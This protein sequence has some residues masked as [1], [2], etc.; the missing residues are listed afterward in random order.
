MLA[1][2]LDLPIGIDVY[3][4]LLSSVLAVFFTFAALASDLLWDRYKRGKRAKHRLL[5]RGRRRTV[6]ASRLSV[7]AREE[8]SNPLLDPLAEEDE[9][10]TDTQDPSSN[11]DSIHALQL[12]AEE[13]LPLHLDSRPHSPNSTQCAPNGN[14]APEFTTFSSNLLSR[15]PPTKPL[16]QDLGSRSEIV[17]PDHASDK[18]DFTDPV[19]RSSSERSTSHRSSSLVDSSGSSYGLSN[20]KDIAYRG[21]PPTK[22][23]FIATVEELYSGYTRKNI[24]KGFS[25]SLAITSMH[26]SGIAALRIPD[27]YFTL[28]PLFVALSALISWVVCTVGCILMSQME[29]HLTRQILFS[30]VA[31]T[32]VA[33]MH[34]TGMRATT[35]WSVAPPSTARGY[36]PE[37]AVAITSI[38]II[39]CFAA[40]GLL[41]HVATVSRNKL[42]EIVW[43]RR[44]LWRTIAQKENA[45]AA[46]RARS[47]FIASASHEIRTP[48]HHL[49]G[50]SDLLSRTD[51]T[52]EGRTLL[53]AIQR[54]TKTLSLITNNVL[55]WSKL[56]RDADASCRPIALDIRTVCESILVL[57]PKK[58]D[59]AEVELL[60]V[61][62][63]NVPHSLF[64]DETYMHR[65]LMN[66]LSNAMKFTGSGYILLLIEI[67]DSQLL[68]TV[69]DTGCGIPP[70][71][72]PQLFEPFK[73]AQTRG[74][75]RGTGLGLSIVKQ[76][77]H[78]MDGT[79][80][81]ESRHPE[82][83][84]VESGQT[85]STFTITIPVQQSGR[86]QSDSLPADASRSIAIFHG[87]NDRSI[88]G[89]CTAWE[90]FEF[91]ITMAK[92]FSEIYEFKGKYIWVDATFLQQDGA[93]LDKLLEQDQWIVLVPYET[94]AMLQQISGILVAPHFF[95]LQKPLI[96]H[97]F[98]RRISA[99]GEP[100]S[101]SVLARTVRFASS[102]NILDHDGTR[103]PQEE[104][105][106]NN[107]IILLVED[108]P[109]NQK[110]GEKMLT[111]LGYQVI[112]AFDGQEAIE[113]VVKHDMTID[114]ILMDQSM[115]T[116]DGVTATKEIREMEEAGKLSRRRPIIALT[117]VVSAQA[118]A[119]FKAAGADDF[120]AKPLSLDKLEQTLGAYLPLQRG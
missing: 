60:V 41:V 70:S 87:D 88:E 3:W 111:S 101:T 74:S 34:F 57:L 78:K 98:Q 30:A 24:F 63:P 100:S 96:W 81:V 2:E 62:A 106:A 120:L 80:E 83:K 42:A 44:K 89:I 91:D 69:K 17:L 93:L 11:S 49:Q 12:E 6:S 50:Y 14:S 38:A 29:T 95:L 118:Q 53:Y 21:A 43:T 64:L 25:W 47:D 82:A 61:V 114:A 85:G 59:E 8:S 22:N 20:I 73:Q 32:G 117:A 36:P 51:L 33:A 19:Q 52:D 68:A 54:A 13:A 5:R 108:N 26:Y 67:N 102:V 92:E 113:Q 48:L 104:P 58:D 86:P 103:E 27:G 112:A 31:T 18:S 28:E 105:T 76:L 119:T 7:I 55:D 109:I 79:I 23:A 94:Q 37:L 4:T 16:S 107:L 71:F 99:A 77:L 15:G 66:L 40:N 75:Q 1:C 45:E 35:F 56:E 97:A 110:L 115:P 90:K 39:T 46:A 116:K 84:G 10:N 72:L 9:D 65:I